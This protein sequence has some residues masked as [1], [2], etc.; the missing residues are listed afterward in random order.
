M[1]SFQRNTYLYWIDSCS[2]RRAA[3]EGWRWKRWD[4]CL[5]CSS[6]ACCTCR[7]FWEMPPRDSGYCSPQQ[8]TSLK[9]GTQ[10]LASFRVRVL[11]KTNYTGSLH[12]RTSLSSSTKSM[13]A[14]F[15]CVLL[16]RSQ[17]F[18][19][20]AYGFWFLYR[21][22]CGLTLMKVNVTF[23]ASDIST[24]TLLLAPQDPDTEVTL[25]S[26]FNSSYFYS[27][28]AQK[29]RD[30]QTIRTDCG[31]SPEDHVTGK[32]TFPSLTPILSPKVA[33]R[34]AELFTRMV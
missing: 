12:T 8:R 34:Q 10:K 7:S 9:R 26:K 16:D 31:G 3:R 23:T 2:L 5:C 18:R 30:N 4:C 32:R 15:L 28:E 1:L 21:D 13:Q 11:H 24:S 6:A 27:R 19:K 14:E 29:R 33:S 20:S 25:G 17:T 22:S